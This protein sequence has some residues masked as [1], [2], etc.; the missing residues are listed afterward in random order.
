MKK[1][2]YLIPILVA[3]LFN[4][5]TK[6]PT[7]PEKINGE[8]ITIHASID[9]Q[10]KT[11]YESERNFSWVANDQLK[12]IVYSTSDNSINQFVFTIQ[13]D[14]PSADAK[15]TTSEDYPQ[16]GYAFYPF[17]NF[18]AGDLTG[19]KDAFKVRLPASYTVA[20]GKE[21]SIIP[22]IGVQSGTY[23]YSFSTA[24]GILKV[25]LSN[26]PVSARK[27]VLKTSN[28]IAGLFPWDA[29]NGFVIGASNVDEPGTDITINISQQVAGSTYSVF[30]P[31]PAGS[32][33]A[34]A[35]IEVQ[36]GSGNVIKATEPTKKA[37][38]ITRNMVT[39]LPAISVEDWVSLGTG[40]FIDNHSFYQA[41]GWSNS[42][43]SSSQYLDVEIQ[44]HKT[45]TNRYRLVHPY[46][47]LFDTYHTTPGEG[48]SGPNDYLTFTVREDIGEGIVLN[49][50]FHTGIDQYGPT[51]YD[52]AELWFDN[53]YWGY[54]SIY[55]NNRIIRYKSDGV[56]PANIQLAPYYMGGLNE[57]CST[58]PKIE[59]VFPGETPMLIFNYSGNST[60]SYAD[61]VVSATVGSDATGVKAVAATSIANGINILQAGTSSDILSF[62]TTGSQNVSLAD[63]NYYLVYKVETDGHGYTYKSAGTFAVTSLQEKTP[64]SV[65]VSNDAGKYDGTGQYDGN[66]A[67]A[68]IDDN[69]STYWHSSY[70]DG[71]TAYY[72]YKD[73][74]ATYG[75][76]IDLDLGA[77]TTVTDFEVR[78]F[79]RGGASTCFPKHVL[80]Y[81][82][83][84][85][86]TW[87]SALA[88]VANICSGVAAGNW[89]N[90]ISC[91]SSEP[92]RYIRFSIIEN[93]IGKDLRD[94]ANADGSS[95]THLAEIKIFG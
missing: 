40:K 77:S 12:M 39:S 57:D 78:A 86:V 64:V 56:T 72:S 69:T 59:I 32:I 54:T 21:M 3:A 26:M 90:P 44:Q 23:A 17:S 42:S 11:A 41:N 65:T 93:T 76:Y 5:C 49:D 8:E 19:T 7:C 80:I 51:Y 91:S 84:D 35:T 67:N 92:V 70:Y 1:T 30:F 37:I 73:L 88:E 15:G 36:D 55:Q 71:Y 48:A 29:T 62:S 22:L 85:G 60:A 94:S 2:L 4:G 25:T 45:E 27:V 75:I 6:E 20:T 58:N 83:A 14:G 52:T 46:A 28:T 38:P 43:I 61:G 66:G 74:D 63:G 10:T 79:L 18:S 89:I 82:S 87:S 13:S 16:T 95:Y 9:E 33:A 68:L 31:V 34:G 81:G 24:T 50:S 47:A 53:P